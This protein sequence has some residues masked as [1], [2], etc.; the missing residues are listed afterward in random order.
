M[1]ARRRDA[2]PAMNFTE[3]TEKHTDA[4]VEDLVQRAKHEPSFGRALKPLYQTEKKEGRTG[5]TESQWR[6]MR[7]MQIAAD[8]DRDQ[9]LPILVAMHKVLPWVEQWHNE[10]DPVRDTKNGDAFRA[11]LDEQLRHHRLTA[12]DLRSWRP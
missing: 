1:A 11:Y 2:V 6:G 10:P 7:Q 3:A 5:E 9:L 4:T 12:N 8:W